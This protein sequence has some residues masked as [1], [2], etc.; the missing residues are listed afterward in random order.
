[1][2]IRTS[3]THPIEVSF[4]ELP[5]PGRLG[6]TFGPGR[7]QASTMGFRWE[8]DL[9]LDLDRLRETWG[10]Q[11]LVTLVE[12]GEMGRL[13]MGGL[14]EGCARRGVGW[15]HVPIPDGGV[16]DPD[17]L[18]VEVVPRLLEA[19]GGGA[20][21]IVHCAGGLGRTG[22]VAGSVLVA[23]G[24]EPE[25]ALEALRAAR[26]PRCPENDGQRGFVRRFGPAF[27]AATARD[28]FRG[29]VLG[30]AI[31]DALGHATEFM[32]WPQIA[33]TWGDG[34][35][36]GFESWRA[37]RDG[38]R[39]A[40]YTDDTQLAEIV[41]RGLV[42]GRA[43]GEDLDGVMG[44]IAPEI[45]RWADEP[46]GGHRAPGNACLRGARRL[47]A[48]VP[49]REAG[50]PNDGGCGSVMRAWPFGLA[51]AADGATAADWAAEHSRSTHG[52]PLALASCAALAAAV[53][54]ALR[55]EAPPEI[56]AAAVEAARTYDAKTAA[57][58]EEAVDLAGGAAGG[59][60]PHEVLRRFQGWAAHE[61]MAAAL[62]V[63][64]RHADDPR[65]ALLEGANA[66]GDS[67]SIASLAG[68]LAGARRG[69]HSLPV[70]WR[71]DVERQ[72]EL[73]ALADR[74]SEVFRPDGPAA[75]G[76]VSGPRGRPGPA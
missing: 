54:A 20:T 33:R 16:P 64:L 6:L 53:S 21:V 34:G 22:T 23:L 8:R 46:L 14:A 30:A 5:L 39:F 45:A 36:T 4:L 15:L 1:M 61:A 37:G 48:G 71:R 56:A 3:T 25:R 67:D 2:E 12:E 57:M 58:L 62:Y 40:A 17:G 35:V 73:H 7:R 55:D 66:D 28:R 52:A 29:A 70:D 75:G 50:G 24:W 76:D 60:D 44:R 43:A 26:G 32:K 41:L 13:G 27:R 47:A 10:A 72:A 19:L 63:F 31:G 68:A 65:A 74:A 42:D 59:D 49:W 69:A 11:L 9:D 38:R 18:A 51:F